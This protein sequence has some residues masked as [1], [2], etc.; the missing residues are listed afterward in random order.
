ME[1]RTVLD[2]KSIG[3]SILPGGNGSTAA[4]ALAATA[5]LV[6]GG[7]SLAVNQYSHRKS[8]NR[9]DKIKKVLE[10]HRQ[11]LTN[12]SGLGLGFGESLTLP[13]PFELEPGS[14]TKSVPVYKALKLTPQIRADMINDRSVN[15]DAFLLQYSR[16]IKA[17][18]IHIQGLYDARLDSNE[19]SILTR[20]RE[21][22]VTSG[23]LTYLL[24]ML[25]EHC[26]KFEGYL[27]DIAILGGIIRFTNAF[28]SLPRDTLLESHDPKKRQRFERLK[29]A[30]RE[31]QQAK[32]LLMD[33]NNSRTLKSYVDELMSICDKDLIPTLSSI[34]AK[35]ITPEESWQ[36]IDTATTEQLVKGVVRQEYRN[37]HQ[38][39]RLTQTAISMPDSI[40]KVWLQN[41][42]AYYD[43][44]DHIV[45]IPVVLAESDLPRI[46]ELFRECPN[47]L[48]LK[49][50]QA[51][52][53]GGFD[54]ERFVPV[55]FDEE[56]QVIIASQRPITPIPHSFVLTRKN[57]IWKA[58]EVGE[59]RQLIKIEID[60]IPQLRTALA[61]LPS[62]KLPESI[63]NRE[64]SAVNTI[65]TQYRNDMQLRARARIFTNLAILLDQLTDLNQFCQKLSDC[66]RDLGEIYMR[67]PHHCNFI[68]E[69]LDAFGKDINDRIGLLF[70]AFEKVE[71]EQSTA[72]D[73]MMKGQLDLWMQLQEKLYNIREKVARK[74]SGMLDKHNVHN[75]RWGNPKAAGAIDFDDYERARK[76][77]AIQIMLMHATQIACK[78]RI[79]SDKYDLRKPAAMLNSLEPR[80]ESELKESEIDPLMVSARRFSPM[81]YTRHHSPMSAMQRLALLDHPLMSARRFSDSQLHENLNA[82]SEHKEGKIEVKEEEPEVIL[83]QIRKRL[84]SIYLDTTERVNGTRVVYEEMFQ[85]LDALD[86][87]MKV[88]EK[89]R[90]SSKRMAKAKQIRQMTIVFCK[91]TQEF[92]NL[93]LQ[94]RVMGAASFI[95]SINDELANRAVFLG[96]HRSAFYRFLNAAKE[97]GLCLL[98]GYGFYRAYKRGGFFKTDSQTLARQFER[99]SAKLARR[100]SH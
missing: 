30:C 15:N 58:S 27:A 77:Q 65:L 79:E 18:K 37:T 52:A 72:I 12:I 56:C 31:L 60:Q 55:S 41:I 53:D 51:N 33:H 93:P 69:T 85:A 1:P 62:K 74:I 78:Y 9:L 25:N 43:D 39:F 29:H 16:H 47:F 82:F 13:P 87:K 84:D 76:N 50:P 40:F 24:V 75:N 2:A 8:G 46:K 22:D 57:G 99:K 68:F 91:K 20:G 89:E 67:N 38:F 98:L 7:V 63:T 19:R 36:F 35:F 86:L 44:P 10:F 95:K 94:Q 45:K 73:M 92:L 21:D 96:E 6:V 23:V 100:L 48:T 59:N 28:A 80:V 61:N 3:N 42:T 17:A 88:M 49:S 71:E 90:Q 5:T 54:T 97:V 81:M 70:K 26:T 83:L 64:K 11:Y 4:V 66:I 34:F 14:E 32:K